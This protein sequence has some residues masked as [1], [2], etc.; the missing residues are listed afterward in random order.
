[1]KKWKLDVFI[2]YCSY[3]F[4]KGI[5]YNKALSIKLY[6]L[7]LKFIDLYY[8]LYRILIYVISF[9][10]ELKTHLK[11]I[12]HLKFETLENKKV[13]KENKNLLN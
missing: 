7:K 1:M 3:N 4:T 10:V 9:Q 11:Q 2:Y 6:K 5:L 12:F 8:L 13:L